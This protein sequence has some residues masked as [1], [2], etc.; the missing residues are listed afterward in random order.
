[1]VLSRRATLARMGNVP[2]D[3]PPV[4]TAVDELC[5]AGKGRQVKSEILFSL[6]H[7]LGMASWVLSLRQIQ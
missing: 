2:V 4:F 3:I 7:Y 5:L 6:S 1:M